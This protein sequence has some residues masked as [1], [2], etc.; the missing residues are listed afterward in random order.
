[1]LIDACHSG[2][3]DKEEMSKMEQVQAKLDSAQK[4]VIVFMDTTNKRTGMKNSFDLMQ[5][6]FVNVGRSTGATVIS[7]ATGTQ[8]APEMDGLKNG[9]FTHS[10]LELMKKNTSVTI[11][12]LKKYVNQRVIEL[13]NGMQVPTSRNE[14]E[15]LD[16]KVW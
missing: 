4:G 5:E 2:E 9:V 13:T 11:S 3:V 15:V 14:N 6:V 16:W 12:E 8:F 7:A 1:M 10:I